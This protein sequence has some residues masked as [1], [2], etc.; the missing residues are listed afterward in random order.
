[1]ASIEELRNRRLEK[2][3][4]LESKGINPYPIESGRESTLLEASL[5]FSELEKK[6]SVTLA[7]RIMSLRGQGAIIFTTL[8]DGTGSF[9]AMVK[10]GD[11][12]EDHFDL[13]NSTTDIGDFVEVN[14]KLFITKRNEKTV[15][16]KSWKML[17]KALLPLPEKWHGLTDTEERFRKRYLD[18]VSSAEVKNRFITRSKIITE[19]RTILEKENFLEVETS[20]L[21]PL[22]GGTNAEPFKTR[23]NALGIDL[24]LRIAQELD[25]KKLIIG[26]YPKVYEIGRNFR[27]EGIDTTHN[28]EFTTVEWYESYS[29][30]AEQRVFVEKIIKTLVK[31]SNGKSKILFQENEINFSKKFAVATFYE[32]LERYALISNPDTVTKA[33][34]ELKANQL[35]IKIDKGDTVEKIMDNI[36]KKSCRTRLIQPTFIIDFPINYL[37]LAKK[38]EG[39][40][41]LVDAFQLVVGGMEIVK[42][43]SELNNPIDQRKRFENQEKNRELGDK[44]AQPNDESF[45]EALEHGMPPAGGVGIGIDRLVMLLTNTKNIRE[46]IFFPTLRPR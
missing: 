24:F 4:I 5:K 38:K 33:E 29:N 16:V 18:L 9:Q 37:P 26:G 10:K 36:Y 31:K 2:L 22:A 3:K 28:P 40:E 23:H 8:N 6:E 1:M 39:S 19:L 20:M 35:G 27:N 41:T 45:I 34:L 7:G 13:F 25:L 12:P 17:S 46:V 43:F 15:L 21:Q 11:T 30:A 32:I 14:G 42:A 44:E